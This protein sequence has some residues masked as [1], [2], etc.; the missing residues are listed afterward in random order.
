MQSL[1]L[2]VALLGDLRFI[3]PA[4]LLVCAVLWCFAKRREMLTMAVS[5]VAALILIGALKYTLNPF[6]A[7]ILSI[8]LH[9][10]DMPSG[11]AGMSTVFYGGIAM[12][13]AR[14]RW[15]W[16]KILAVLSIGVPALVSV[17]VWLLWWHTPFE[18]ASGVLVGAVALV[19]GERLRA[20]IGPR[21]STETR[22]PL[23]A[24][25]LD[26]ARDSRQRL[27]ASNQGGARR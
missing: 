20:A 8:E 17:S 19:L 23:R 11:H 15:A 7:S 2:K 16:A 27:S 4:C 22:A 1:W 21:A 3:V 24:R 26:L 6:H 10:R 14:P 9:A 18:I 13:L 5:L 12:L 25:V